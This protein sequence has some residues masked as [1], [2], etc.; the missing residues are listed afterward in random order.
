MKYIT[1]EIVWLTENHPESVV[2]YRHPLP[3]PGHPCVVKISPAAAQGEYEVEQTICDGATTAETIEAGQVP[4]LLVELGVM[5][6]RET[7]VPDLPE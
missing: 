2:I 3:Q 7:I 5:T 1:K 6:V 4:D